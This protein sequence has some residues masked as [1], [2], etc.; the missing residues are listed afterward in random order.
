MVRA[1]ESITRIGYFVRALT[2]DTDC[3]SKV[4]RPR[5]YIIGVCTDTASSDAVLDSALDLV[6]ATVEERGKE[7]P[8]DVHWLA[9]VVP[10]A[11]QDRELACHTLVFAGHWQSFVASSF[12]V[13]PIVTPG[14][15]AQPSDRSKLGGPLCSRQCPRCKF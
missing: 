12:R 15:Q 13:A 7:P 4:R 14:T 3:W 11:W 2:L 1:L 6:A 10:K 8:R 5:M 9:S